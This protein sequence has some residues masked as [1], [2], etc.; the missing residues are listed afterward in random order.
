MV[1][2]EVAYYAFIIKMLGDKIGDGENYFAHPHFDY[3][4]NNIKKKNATGKEIKI[5]KKRS[6]NLKSTE[7]MIPVTKEQ[8]E[9]LVDKY[10]TLLISKIDEECNLDVIDPN[11]PAMNYT[12]KDELTNLQSLKAELSKWK[13]IEYDKEYIKEK[14]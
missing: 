12:R 6:N 10:K 11:Y 9:Y 14:K 1:I 3:L 8:E 5:N 2:I 13:K 7:K 4:I